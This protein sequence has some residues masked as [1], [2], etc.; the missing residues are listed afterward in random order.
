MRAVTHLEGK[1]GERKE[2]IY[3]YERGRRDRPGRG[4]QLESVCCLR[5]EGGVGEI[6]NFIEVRERLFFIYRAI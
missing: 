4:G 2:K 1:E 5:E 3:M 6:G